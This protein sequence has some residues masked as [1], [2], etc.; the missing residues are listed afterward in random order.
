MLFIETSIF[1]R[2]ILELLDDESYRALQEYLMFHPDAGA[3]IPGSG[4][5]RKLRWRVPG[6]GKRGGIRIIYYWVVAKDVILLLF[7]FRKNERSDLTPE[8]LRILRQ[9]VEKDYP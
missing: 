2:R 7:V 1:T 9:I 5:L 8:Q 3:V 6:A 4:G